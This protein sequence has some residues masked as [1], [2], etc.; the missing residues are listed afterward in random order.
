MKSMALLH[1]CFA[2]LNDRHTNWQVSVFEAEALLALV[3]KTLSGLRSK[4]LGGREAI[5]APPPG[6]RG[7]GLTTALSTEPNPLP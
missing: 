4:R 2:L 3:F 6:M 5:Q 1:A 7:V